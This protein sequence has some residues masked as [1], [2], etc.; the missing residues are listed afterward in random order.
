MDKLFKYVGEELRKLLNVP[1]LRLE[2][3][4]ESDLYDLGPKGLRK[5][6]RLTLDLHN[7][8]CKPFMHSYAANLEKSL[9][10]TD[11]RITQSS[12]QK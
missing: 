6:I 7:N 1:I 8:Y 10:Q 4:Y 11:L 3:L 2:G 12:S 9:K 5:Y